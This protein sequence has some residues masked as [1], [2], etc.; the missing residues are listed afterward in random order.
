MALFPSLLLLLAQNPAV[1]FSAHPVDGQLYP[2]NANSVAHVQVAGRVLENG[3][4]SVT[5]VARRD[6]VPFAFKQQDLNYN[7]IGGAPFDL[8]I[9][10]NAELAEYDFA[11]LLR[12]DSG[13][14]VV[15]TAERVVA[16]DAFLIQGQSNAVANDSH[17]QNLA[18][19]DQSPWIRSFGT[20][21]LFGS[22]A[23]ADVNWYIADG[24]YDREEGA[25]GAWGLRMASNIVASEGIPVAI[26]NGAVGATPIVWHQR[27][28]ADP[29]DVSTN[30]GRL[31]T[32]ATNAGLV[33]HIRAIFWYQ[34]EADGDAAE[35]YVYRF[36]NLYHDWLS[37][38]PSTEKVYVFQVRNGCGNPSPDLRNVQ[39]R[40][41]EFLSKVDVMSTTAINRHDGCHYYYGGY[42]QL[43][44]RISRLVARDLYGSTDTV[45]I[46]APYLA[47]AS[48]GDSLGNSIRLKFADPDDRLIVEPGAEQD[49][50]LED[51][52]QV[53][54][55]QVAGSS[56]YLTLSGPSNSATIAYVGHPEDGAWIKNGRGVGALA[57]KVMI[58]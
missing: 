22:N 4:D 13:R 30:Y 37:D 44:N 10:I 53:V 25:I 47:W 46:D 23:A 7:P 56:I 52:V 34:G 14:K 28:D 57:F 18:N 9:K 42:R 39:R 3:W 33:D 16:G 54:S 8:N 27:N 29:F 26:L 49:F 36:Y 6:G 11:I 5:C 58:R 35:P 50:V 51:G 24:E 45:E 19:Q 31:L 15:G 2:R 40:F 1:E 20:T 55:T 38:Y 12:N 32:R 43:G 41:K 48:W 17:N 21:S